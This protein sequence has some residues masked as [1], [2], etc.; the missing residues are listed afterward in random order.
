M[1]KSEIIQSEWLRIPEAAA[2]AKMSRALVYE[3]IGSG[4][5]KS[6]LRKSHPANKSGTRLVSR[7]S[8]DEW[9]NGQAEAARDVKGR[10]LET[11]R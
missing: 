4:T 5:I 7:T 2:Y 9:M 11:T 6:F 1:I 10:K 3:L 8:I